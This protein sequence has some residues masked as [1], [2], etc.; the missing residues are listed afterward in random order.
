LLQFSAGT[1]RDWRNADATATAA[2][3]FAAG[4]RH[5]FAVLIDTGVPGRC[6]ARL[7]FR[8]CGNEQR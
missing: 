4:F 1:R 6:N 2:V 7:T 5:D 8:R 3:L